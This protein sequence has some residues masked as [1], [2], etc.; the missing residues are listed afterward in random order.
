M[1]ENL[2]R[3]K[4]RLNKQ[5]LK[6]KTQNKKQRLFSKL[7]TVEA[8]LHKLYRQTKTHEEAKAVNSINEN[9][10]YFFSYAKRKSKIK[11]KIGPLLNKITGEMTIDSVEMADILAE[12][13]SSVFS[14]PAA[15]PPLISTDAAPINN[16]E[17]SQAD[18][19]NAIDEIKPTAAAGPDGIPAILLKKCKN[20]LAEPLTTL[21]NKC[22]ETSQI[23][24]SLKEAIIPPIHKGG[25][26]AD[27]ANYR[28]V[29]LTSHL[30]KI[31]EKAIR[32]RLTKH[33]DQQELLNQNQHGFRPGR[34]CLTQLL[35]HFDNIVSLLEDGQNVDVIYLDFSKAFDKVDHN[36]LLTK[37]S[38]IRINGKTLRWIQEFLT[39]RTQR[40]MVNGKLSAPHEVKSGVPQGSVLGPLLFLVLINDIDKATLHSLIASFADDTRATHGI[41]NQMDASNLQNDLFQIY[42][43]SNMNNMKFNSLKFEL[44]RYG[45][46]K[47]LKENTSYVTPDWDVIEQKETV[48][49]LGVSMSADNTFKVHIANIAESAKKMASWVLRTFETRERTPMMTLYKTLVRPLLEYSSP[50]WTPTSKE[51]IKKLEDIQKSFVK[52]IKGVSPNYETACKQLQLYTL[53]E[54]RARYLAIHIWKI[55]EELSPNLSKDPNKCIQQ[56]TDIPHRR[57]RTC[58]IFNLTRTPSHLQ[59]TRKQTIRCQGPKIFN[60]LPKAIRNLTKINMTTFKSKL[61]NHLRQKW[62]LSAAHTCRWQTRTS[63]HHLPSSSSSSSI[64]AAV[65]E[66][67]TAV[68]QPVPVPDMPLAR[69][70]TAI[71]PTTLG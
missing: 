22:M 21:W 36:I 69:G 41:K 55:L 60:S 63:H 52:K 25:S 50:L 31:Y 39:N 4:R 20:A 26:K 1:K 23:P 58:R 38:S 68:P 32:N 6:A 49:D 10:K 65:I 18:L 27:P 48:K 62:N 7:I 33:L 13:Y 46:D 61:D 34:S 44:L 57:G 30:I 35:A 19:I 17:I 71:V 9:T 51:E 12:Q 28:P 43:W 47:D 3:K 59:K 42:H 8:K 37:L 56:Q 2:H 16:I 54:R 11:S 15:Q 14:I 53:E 70:L 45:K 67:N 66:H 5:I 40:V 24:P 64:S 29:A